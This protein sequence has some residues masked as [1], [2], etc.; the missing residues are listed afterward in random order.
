[1]IPYKWGLSSLHM[2]QR[3]K[4]K[5]SADILLKHFFKY[6]IAFEKKY[7]DWYDKKNYK[8]T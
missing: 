7:F 3:K 6:K 8:G 4:K 1:M 5:Q 2:D